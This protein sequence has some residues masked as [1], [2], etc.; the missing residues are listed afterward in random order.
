[1]VPPNWAELSHCTFKPYFASLNYTMKTDTV[2]ATALIEANL[3][4]V[5]NALCRP[6]TRYPASVINGMGEFE[7]SME[8]GKTVYY[9][10]AGSPGET[11][12][13]IRLGGLS[14]VD[15]KTKRSIVWSQS[16]GGVI[17]QF[18]SLLEPKSNGVELRVTVTT[19][20]SGAFS[21]FLC[22]TL[23]GWLRFLFRGKNM[24]QGYIKNV[25]ECCSAKYQEI[26]H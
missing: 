10:I 18:S 25:A 19:E 16:G 14:I 6:E 21:K 20:Y 12:K 1:M 7:E 3:E 26:D 2:E 17:R 15:S 13:T 4:A 8:D 24:A 23:P 9:P 22:G 11:G 5:W